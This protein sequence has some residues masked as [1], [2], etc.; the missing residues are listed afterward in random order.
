MTLCSCRFAYCSESFHDR[1]MSWWMW[2]LIAWPALSL[3]IAIVIGRA[4]RLGEKRDAQRR[5]RG[6]RKSPMTEVPQPRDP[7]DERSA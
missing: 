6:H 4:I 1:T 3:P 7:S 5:V 2:A